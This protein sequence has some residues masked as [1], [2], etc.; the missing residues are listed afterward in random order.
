MNPT[1]LEIFSTFL[2]F[3]AIIHTFLV[4]KFRMIAHKKKPMSVSYHVWHL[5]SEV[6]IVFGFWSFVFLGFFALSKGVEAATGYIESLNFTEPAFVFVIMCIASTRPIIFFARKIIEF[7][8]RILPFSERTSFYVSAL[9]IGPLFGSFITEPAAMTVTAMILLDTIYKESISLKLKYATLALLFVN[10]SIGGTLT[11][12]AAPPVLMVASKWN[13][14]SLFMLKNFGF[15]AI[16]AVIVSTSIYSLFFRKELAGFI[17]RSAKEESHLIPRSWD[18]L[19]HILFMML[20]VIFAHH[21]I[22]FIAIFFAFLGFMMITQ[23]TQE[24]M[25]V[26]ESLMVAFFLAGL[27]VLGSMQ[28]WWLK[29]L[30][31]QMGNLALFFG[32]AAL[33]SITDNAAITYLG[34]FVDL[35]ESAKYF[36]VAGAVSGGGLTVIAN[37]PN[38]AGFAILGDSFGNEG[39][40]P[41]RL[42]LWALVPTLIAILFFLIH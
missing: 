1:Y 34:S 38:P 35:S 25:K 10:V 29:V 33:T 14:G 24:P 7:V 21:P 13:W 37:A 12:F 18:I 19:I 22:V 26:K 20:V 32:S 40:N 36:L 6:E 16:L 17:K 9:I 31:S 39:I 28:S 3:V 30:I 15:K 41:L 4:G 2:F 23:E 8:A 11:S 42:F 27:V 5:L